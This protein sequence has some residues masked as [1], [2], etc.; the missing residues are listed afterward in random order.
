MSR[1]RLDVAYDGTAYAGWQIQPNGDTIQA[2]LE[3]ALHALTG[4]RVTVHGSG[5]TDRGVH[6][7]RQPAHLDLVRD[8]TPKEL[9]TGLNALLPPDIRVLKAAAAA[10]DFHARRNAIA[11]EYRYFIWNAEVLPPP[12]RLYRTHVPRRLDVSAMQRAAAGL[13]GC[14]D[15]AS[16]TANPNRPVA[17][18]VR[19]LSVLHVVKRGSE[20]TV[21]A[22]AEGFLYRMVRSL[23]GFLIRVGQG[24]EPAA[25]TAAMLKARTRTAHV[26]T[27]PPQGLFLWRVWY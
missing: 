24:A 9:K 8:R 15:F 4:E 12:L 5:R 23:A 19:T 6:A 26:P 10:P 25:R 22:R 11:K 27:A 18:T 13:A 21:T 1:Y 14:H 16:F 7:R 2:Q 17:S 20:I 3:T